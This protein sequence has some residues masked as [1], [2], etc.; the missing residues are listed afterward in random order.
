MLALIL[1]TGSAAQNQYRERL[2]LAGEWQFTTDSTEKAEMPE[3]LC[4]T[5]QLPGT[6]DTNRKGFPIEKKDETTRL[7]RLYSYVGKAFYSRDITIPKEWKGKRV[8]MHLERTKPTTVI[9]D[10]LTAGKCND[11]STEQVFD[12]TQYLKPGKHNITVAVDNGLTAVPPQLIS[13]SHA[14][15]EDTQTNWNG[16][17]GDF[18]LEAVNSLCIEDVSV[19]PSAENRELDIT[20]H[21]NGEVRKNA[22]LRII[23]IPWCGDYGYIVAQKEVRKTKD[24]R[25]FV[26]YT[27]TIR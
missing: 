27:E 26:L 25:V 16:I 21:I 4:G 17:I 2:W 10:G 11:I 7:S 8:Y 19:I 1:A 20:V 23:L 13:S 3:N 5:V 12:L 18:Y 22:R 6:T 24:N 9:V 14:Y 15:T